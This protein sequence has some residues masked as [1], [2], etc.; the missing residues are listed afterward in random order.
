[1]LAV[2]KIRRMP[3]SSRTRMRRIF[4]CVLSRHPP[5]HNQRICARSW[6]SGS[7]YAMQASLQAS[8]KAIISAGPSGT[9]SPLMIPHYENVLSLLR[10]RSL[11]SLSL[12]QCWFH[13]HTV[14]FVNLA[15]SHRLLCLLS[16]HSLCTP[17]A[18]RAAWNHRPV[19]T[20]HG[21]A[22]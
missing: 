21:S 7:Q 20:Y 15:V 9:D 13:R 5:R 18:E 2:Q 22:H 4:V 14:S 17:C 11:R 12:T 10:L 6:G 16:F 1:M 19:Q 3:F 8:A